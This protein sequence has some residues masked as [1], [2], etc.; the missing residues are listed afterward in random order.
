[1]RVVVTGARGQLGAAIVHEFCSAHEVTALGREE[2]DVTDD[3]AV[4]EKMDA[5]H[6][7]A[8]VNTAAYN[9]VDGAEDHPVEALNGNAFAVRALARAA[10]RAGSALVHYSTDFVFD[11]MTTKPYTED[12]KPNPRS[13]YAASKLLG[14]WFAADTSRRYV[15]RVES[16]FGHAPGGPKPRGSISAM[17]NGFA[18]R[19]E[20]RAFEDRT[21]SPTY[22]SDAARA[23]RQLLEQR[24][25]P[26]LYHCV[27]TG[28]CTWLEFARELAR[29]LGTEPRIVPVRMADATLRAQRPRYCALS[30]EKLRSAGVSMPAWQDALA[31]YLQS[32]RDDLAH[33]VPYR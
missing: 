18:S 10:E 27:N 15:L 6:P 2:L 32:V 19:G 8:I 3:A 4:A 33:Q 25:Q 23:T 16:L 5:L 7:D 30:N 24:A 26:G 22:I 29:Q 12:D 17:L 31:R 1:M 9:D 28:E 11:G 21:V 20:V 13:V 14:E